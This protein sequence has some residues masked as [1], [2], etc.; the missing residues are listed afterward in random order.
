VGL[1][2]YLY[3][4][5]YVSGAEWSDDYEKQQYQDIVTAIRANGIEYRDL[6]SAEVKLKVGYW[7]K[8][9]AIHQW[10]VKNVQGGVDDCQQANVTREQLKELSNICQEVLK[11]KTKTEELLPAMEGFLFGHT[12]YDNWYYEQLEDTVKTLE[13]LL[14]WTEGEQWWTFYYQSSW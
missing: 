11:D 6:P 5:K 4:E 12:E 8:A 10:F 7:R 3:A 2:M 9:N 1:D 14:K 13:N